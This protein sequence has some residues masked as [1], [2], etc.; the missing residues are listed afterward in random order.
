VAINGWDRGIV[1]VIDGEPPLGVEAEEGIVKRRSLL[2]I[3]DT[4]SGER[5]PGV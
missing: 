3:W 4:S 5:S 2:R 1:G